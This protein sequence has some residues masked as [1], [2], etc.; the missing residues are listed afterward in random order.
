MKRAKRPVIV[1]ERKGTDGLITFYHHITIHGNRERVRLES[2]GRHR[3]NTKGYLVAKQSAEEAAL[4]KC[5]DIFRGD[6]GII[7]NRGGVKFIKL[8]E[9]H[10]LGKA[11]ERMRMKVARAFWK[12]T[13]LAQ[14][15][16]RKVEDYKKDLMS[17][18]ADKTAFEL[19]TITCK[20]VL[21]NAF[22]EGWIRTDPSRR[23]QNPPNL[24]ATKLPLLTAEEARLWLSW[25]RVVVSRSGDA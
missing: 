12:S 15:T 6:F 14:V 18:Y 10:C 22:E 23:V 11:R 4:V 2:L 25:E 20:A 13:T 19:F 24:A 17:R 9:E 8:V 21:R 7:K 16:P 5:A 3:F 1:Y